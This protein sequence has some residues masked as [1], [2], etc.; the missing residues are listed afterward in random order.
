M[1]LPHLEDDRVA[2]M[3]GLVPDKR[4]PSERLWDAVRTG[5]QSLRYRYEQCQSTSREGNRCERGGPHTEHVAFL[6]CGARLSWFT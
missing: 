1:E 5:G 6:S 3:L 2:M 4:T